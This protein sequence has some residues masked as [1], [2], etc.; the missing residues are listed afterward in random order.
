LYTR[1]WVV[2]ATS[3][4]AVLKSKDYTHGTRALFSILD[5]RSRLRAVKQVVVKVNLVR[6]PSYLDLP[7]SDP[8]PKTPVPYKWHGNKGRV[9]TTTVAEDGDITRRAH[10]EALITCLMDLGIDDITLCEGACGW[11]TDLAYKSLGFYELGKK[12]GVKVVDTNWAEP[13]VI[14]IRKGK[15][16]KD[17]WLAKEYVDAD[18]RINL[19][20]LKIHGATC[21][22]LCLKNWAIG[23]PSAIRYG[24]NRTGNRIRGKGDSF[25]IHQHYDREE[26]Y[27]QGVGIAQTI[28]DVN[29]AL[30]YE[31]GII[32]GMT[33]IHYGSLMNAKERHKTRGKLPVFKTKLL[34]ASYDRVAVDAVASRVMG[35]NPSK[36]LHIYLAAE[37]GCGT[38]DQ[39]K[40]EVVGEKVEDVQLNGYPMLKQREVM[41]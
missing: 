20:T 3:R 23:V 35:L 29:S 13:T 32:D 7:L 10:V 1:E 40:M 11:D 4:V 14:P 38:L 2:A 28:A 6:M 12:Y 37:K 17:L 9:Y 19:T 26:W 15:M 31:L 24:I 8:N 39:P 5:V 18:F 36:I 34:L 33:A 41:L 25:P 22:S 30:P 21:V 16:L 27:G